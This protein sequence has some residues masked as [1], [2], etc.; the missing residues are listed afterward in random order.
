MVLQECE[1]ILKNEDIKLIEQIHVA[2][3][4]RVNLLRHN[5]LALGCSANNEIIGIPS[6]PLTYLVQL[7]ETQHSFHKKLLIGSTKS[8]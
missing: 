6:Y 1:K 7:E 2:L 3:S 5:P 4:D 8:M